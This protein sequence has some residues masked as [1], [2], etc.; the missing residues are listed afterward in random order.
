[1]IRRSSR[2]WETTSAAR[3]G[4]PP[5]AGP[6]QMS[7][8]RSRY[9]SASSSRPLA[10]AD[11]APGESVV[12][13]EV[14]ELLT[15]H[16]DGVP[17]WA[18]VDDLRTAESPAQRGDA[19]LDLTTRAGRRGIVPNCADQLFHGHDMVGGHQQIGQHYTLPRGGYRHGGTIDHGFQ[20]SENPELD[21]HH[22]GQHTVSRN[23]DHQ[24]RLFRKS[25]GRQ[26]GALERGRGAGIP[27]VTSIRREA[28]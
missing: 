1:M 23:D 7:I 3:P 9:V 21:S 18:G 6:D 10:A 27:R 16:P 22:V 8:A 28:V 15:V 26:P 13:H 20:C 19:D 14:V 12:E 2:R 17:E 24:S 4:T 5:N 11:P 25:F